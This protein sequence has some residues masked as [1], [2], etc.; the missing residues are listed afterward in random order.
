MFANTLSSYN[1]NLHRK[2]R[3]TVVMS[4][5]KPLGK[6]VIK[7]SSVTRKKMIHLCGLPS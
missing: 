4:L 1:D 2:M 3:Q 7:T 6:A 5:N